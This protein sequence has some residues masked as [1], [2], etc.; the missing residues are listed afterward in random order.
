MLEID[1]QEDRC[2]KSPNLPLWNFL[3]IL[4]KILEDLNICSQKSLWIQAFVLEYR[5]KEANDESG[6]LNQSDYGHKTPP[7][8]VWSKVHFQHPKECFFSW[9]WVVLVCSSPR[10]QEIRDLAL[11][12]LEGTTIVIAAI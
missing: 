6:E 4:I 8:Q 3:G 7:G 5:A 1:M 2:D 10:A 11:L 12:T 9:C